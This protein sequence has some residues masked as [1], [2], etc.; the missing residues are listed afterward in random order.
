MNEN[1]SIRQVIQETINEWFSNIMNEELDASILKGWVKQLNWEGNPAMGLDSYKKEFVNP[2]DGQ[3]VPV[4]IFGKDNDWK[5]VVSA[6][7]KSE[8]SYSGSF[9]PENPSLDQAIQII[10]HKYRENKLFK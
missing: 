5:F 10:D 1:M 8:Y 7:P 2:F 3:T 4:Y 9:Y 6:G